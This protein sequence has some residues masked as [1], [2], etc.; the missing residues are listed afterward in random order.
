V[1]RLLSFLYLL[2]HKHDWTVF[3]LKGS[4]YSEDGVWE[5]RYCKICGK[6]EERDL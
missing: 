3:R 6:Y 1:N 2:F 4:Y 5:E